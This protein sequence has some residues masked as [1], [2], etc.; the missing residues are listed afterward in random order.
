MHA[1]FVPRLSNC[2]FLAITCNLIQLRISGFT[3]SV[4]SQRGNFAVEAYVHV[5]ILG[6]TQTHPAMSNMYSPAQHKG[7]Y[8]PSSTRAESLLFIVANAVCQKQRLQ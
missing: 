3:R 1:G 2:K 7:L 4:R 6:E 8:G 5:V